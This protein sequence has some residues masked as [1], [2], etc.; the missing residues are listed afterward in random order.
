MPEIILS[1]DREK[2]LQQIREKF[3][4][5]LPDD[6]REQLLVPGLEIRAVDPDDEGPLQLEGY[7]AVFDKDSDG[8]WFI[9]RIRKG[10]FA[11]TIKEDDIAALFNHDRNQVLGRNTA[12]TLALEEDKTG[13]KYI[14]DLPDTQVGRD[15]HV[16]VKRGDVKGSSF[17]FQT[18]KDEWEYLDDGETV[19]RTLL[20]VKLFDVGP[21]TFPAY[22]DTT[23]A[24]RSLN[25]WLGEQNA[26]P[27]VPRRRNLARRKLDLAALEN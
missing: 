24:V 20:K 15:L 12:E 18:Q 5:S 21:V 9:E 2:R 17:S 27:E 25:D 13:L 26:V 11:D 3:Y 7:A 6:K 14:I 22:P 8:F 10:A 1:N 19:I 4:R 16:V 23:T